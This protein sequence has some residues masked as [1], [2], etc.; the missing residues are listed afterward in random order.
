MSTD[1]QAK[2]DPHIEALFRAG[3]HFGYSKSRRH[4]ST[5][6]YVFGLKNGAE[7]IDLEK[8]K[9]LLATAEHFVRMLAAEGKTLMLVG[10]KKETQAAIKEASESLGLPYVSHR[11]IGG[12][13][14]NWNEI[15]K[16]LLRL[17]DLSSKRE[18]GELSVYTKR[19]RGVI[20]REIAKLELLFGGIASLRSLPHAL[21]IIDPK[22][23]HAAV[24][25]AKRLRLPV[26]ALASTDC[27]LAD[28]DYPI[29]GNDAARAS[30]RYFI[31]VLVKAFAE[32]RTAGMPAAPEPE[33]T[34]E[35]DAVVKVPVLEE[36]IA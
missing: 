18:R 13:L 4:P 12:T 5:R 3:A 15:K 17:E 9:D 33:G 8:T 20:D 32:G 11:W 2:N 22:E 24:A 36:T 21:L 31:E 16:R 10:T 34:P 35:D 28:I 27:D 30:V 29:V 1:T 19:E 26:V 7:I 6:S 14:T 25:E 23:E